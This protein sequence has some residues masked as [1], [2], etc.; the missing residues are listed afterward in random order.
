MPTNSR[1]V[2]YNVTVGA[3]H[4][5][6]TDETGAETPF[7]ALFYSDNAGSTPNPEMHVIHLPVDV[8][9]NLAAQLRNV[10]KIE[11]ASITDIPSLEKRRG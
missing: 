8:A 3:E 7:V 4:G 10:P 5:V 9:E 2:H 11:I 1:I 6:E